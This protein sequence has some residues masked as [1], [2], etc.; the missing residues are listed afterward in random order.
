M[1]LIDNGIEFTP[2]GLVDI[3]MKRD[4]KNQRSWYAM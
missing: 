1:Q 2:E 4:S 3:F